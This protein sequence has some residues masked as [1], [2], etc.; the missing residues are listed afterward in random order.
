VTTLVNL[1]ADGK[2]DKLFKHGTV[3]ENTRKEAI[4]KELH[5]LLHRKGAKPGSHVRAPTL[6]EAR[7]TSLPSAETM[8]SSINAVGDAAT[9]SGSMRESRQGL[10]RAVSGAQKRRRVDANG[11]GGGGRHAIDHAAIETE[12]FRARVLELMETKIQFDMEQRAKE[13]ELREHEFE[14]QKRFLEY[15]QSK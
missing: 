2:H 12:N 5:A 7:L 11:G 15:L 10:G 9:P 6:L 3:E 13:N 1:Y 8:G 4:L 14:L